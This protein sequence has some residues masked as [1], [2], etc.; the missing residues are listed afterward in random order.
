[1]NP[2]RPIRTGIIGLGRSGRDIHAAHLEL[3]K[4]RYTIVAA[5]DA[6]TDRQDRA[7]RELGCRVYPTYRDMVEQ[8]TLDLVVNAS[9]SHLHYPISLDLLHRG[10]HTLCE[11][12]LAYTTAEVDRLLEASAKSGA[13]LSV[14]QQAR[15]LP[16]FR[17]LHKVIRSGILGRIV[18]IHFTNNQFARRWD[19]QTLQ[20]NHGGNL[21][22]TGPHPLDQA[23][24]LFGDGIEPEVM[25]RMDRAVTLGDA[26]DYVKLILSGPGR[27]TID[28]E[29]SSCSAYPQPKFV[30]Q[31]TQGG[32]RGDTRRLEWKYFKPEQLP[33]QKLIREPLFDQQ[34]NPAYC[35]E[36]IPWH[37]DS[38]DMPFAD[39]H[40]MNRH[41]S[42]QFYSM[43]YRTLAHGEP[44]EIQ[45]VH[46][47]RQMAVMEA[48]RKQNPHIY[49]GS[50][51]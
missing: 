13:I 5:T 28:M 18:Q 41:M 7:V 12:P 43:L 21:A 17:Q 50:S 4:D 31:G 39:E 40:E 9:P 29:I 20:D 32:L 16:A 24:L 19:W 10:I 51:A 26:E 48:C 1:M 34:G 45:V 2:L 14:F 33:G 3:M 49:T 35:S 38:W 42:E 25:C 8:E 22:N 30:V 36:T 37:E 47:R 46:A 44:C 27:P 6:L 15:Y 23:L 11:K